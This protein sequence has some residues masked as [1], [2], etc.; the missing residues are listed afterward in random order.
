MGKGTPARGR[1]N[2]RT[3]MLCRRCGN[4]SYNI[5][6]SFCTSCNFGKSSKLKVEGKTRRRAWPVPSKQLKIRT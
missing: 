6:K 4:H 5:R 2:K 1:R 3:H